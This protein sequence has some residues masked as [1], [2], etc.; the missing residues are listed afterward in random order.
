MIDPGVPSTSW[1]P[2][3]PAPSVSFFSVPKEPLLAA[4]V[5]RRAVDSDRALSFVRAAHALQDSVRAGNYAISGMPRIARF[6][7]FAALTKAL[8]AHTS[9]SRLP[10]THA[11]AYAGKGPAISKRI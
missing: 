2:G 3:V 11:A 6:S 5:F 8:R 9:G 1:I 4:S 7:L 10:A